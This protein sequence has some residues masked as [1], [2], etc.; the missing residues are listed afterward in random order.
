[1]TR[2]KN[3]NELQLFLESSIG[4][5]QFGKNNTKLKSAMALVMDIF[6]SSYGSERDLESDLG[7]WLTI[8]TQPV[9]DEQVGLKQALNGVEVIP[10]WTDE[11]TDTDDSNRIWKVSL[12]VLSADFNVVLVYAVENRQGNY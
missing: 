4:I 5:S 10:E 9:V 3:Q 11:Y 7:G 6:D 8:L 2:I 1:M 12:F